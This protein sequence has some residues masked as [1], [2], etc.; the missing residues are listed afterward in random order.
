[1]LKPAKKASSNLP[2]VPAATT[3]PPKS[4]AGGLAPWFAGVAE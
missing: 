2:M 4:Q 3:H 1:L